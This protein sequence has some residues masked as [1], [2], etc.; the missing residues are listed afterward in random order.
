MDNIIFENNHDSKENESNDEIK[1]GFD[2]VNFNESGIN[3]NE[4]R[5]LNKKMISN[6]RVSSKDSNPK[7]YV[8]VVSR[9]K[10]LADGFSVSK[11]FERA[12]DNEV[13]KLIE[14]ACFR[15]KSNKRH[16]LMERDV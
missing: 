1:N 16:T 11:E 6:E 14:R 12:L 3:G 9:V 5:N 7:G 2:A 8:I 13:K 15:A 10:E 4:E